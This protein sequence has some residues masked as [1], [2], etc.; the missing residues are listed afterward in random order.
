MAHPGSRG[1]GLGRV[2]TEALIDDATKA[3]IESVQLGVRGNNHLAVEL[4]R[5]LGFEIWGTL[6]N[7]IAVGEE[8]FDDVRMHRT[9]ARPAGVRLRGSDADGPGGSR[10]AAAR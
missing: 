9:L 8:R 2:V 3:G 5:S 10:A 7:V 6:P 4:Y 1:L